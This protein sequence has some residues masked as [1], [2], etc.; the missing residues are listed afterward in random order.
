MFSF[1]DPSLSQ[2]L[3]SPKS[4]PLLTKDFRIHVEPQNS[5]HSS[6]PFQYLK[7]LVLKDTA[8]PV[9]IQKECWENKG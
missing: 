7:W 5:L 8:N 1:P 6:V 4:S 3:S 9:P 2:L